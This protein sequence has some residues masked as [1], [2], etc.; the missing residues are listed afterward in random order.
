M[1]QFEEVVGI[2]V[3]KATLDA[4]LHQRAAYT[5]VDNN[6][7]GFKTLEKWVKTLLLVKSHHVIWC[8]EHTGMYSLQLA[9]YLS[10][11]KI[12]FVLV[13]PLKIK[14]SLGL[15]R[16]KN[17]KVDAKRIAEY[18][19]LRREKLTPTQLPSENVMSLKQL[20]TLRERMVTQRAGYKTSLIEF[21]GVLTKS[22]NPKVF[23]AQEAMIKSL[24]KS[25]KELEGE[26]LNLIRS[27]EKIFKIYKLLTSIIGIGMVVAAN[28]IVVTNCFTGFKNSRQLAC[29]CGVAPFE[30]QSGTRLKSKSKVSHIANKRLK[31]LLDRSAN[32]AIQNDP[33]L[34]LYYQRR[35]EQGKTSYST[36][37]VVRNKI[38]HRVFAVIQRETPYVKIH[39]HAA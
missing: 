37:N 2:D 31:A 19:Y 27:D 5:K 7:E 24:S 10:E 16:G 18:A 29:Y 9:V 17:D 12:P 8:F 36:L 20:L 33:E 35:L 25:I 14:R 23:T 32:T 21:T 11:R 6:K 34:K 38:L 26:I 28:L 13:P 4:H 22:K 30:K 1:K 39:R 15:V 3:S